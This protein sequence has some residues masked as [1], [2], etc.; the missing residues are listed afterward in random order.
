VLG[1]A[2]AVKPKKNNNKKITYQILGMVAL[3]F[4]LISIS[5]V[6]TLVL[7]GS[8]DV[9]LSEAEPVAYIV[10]AEKICVRRI[11]S[12]YSQRMSSVTVDDRSSFLDKDAGKYKLHY[13]LELFRD[14]AKKSGVNTFFVNCVV[15][16][17][18]GDITRI[19]YL[20]QLDFKPKAIRRE[21]G[22]A[23]GF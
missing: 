14:I 19:E 11:K 16:A 23:F 7:T 9:G 12:D 5:T 3:L 13:Q 4:L 10:D 6:A 22:N 20:E 17:A 18:N 2:M 21:K 1:E 8:V 15:S